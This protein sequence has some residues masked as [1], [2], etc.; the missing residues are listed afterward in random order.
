MKWL[1]IFIGE[2]A[3]NEKVNIVGKIIKEF[4]N[5]NKQKSTNHMK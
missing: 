2:Q 3:N 5:L 1:K 4:Q